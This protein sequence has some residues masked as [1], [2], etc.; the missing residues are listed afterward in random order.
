MII[1][2]NKL[3]YLFLIPSL[4][5]G[6][7]GCNDS[8]STS[9]DEP[10]ISDTPVDL[11]SKH[12]D[13]PVAYIAPQCYTKTED[14][15]SRIYNSCYTCHKAGIEPNFI[16]DS[17]LQLEYSFPA[18]A[19]QNPWSNL[20]EDRSLRIATISDQDILSYV[21][22][23]NYHDDAGNILLAQRLATVPEGWDFDEDGVWDGYVPDCYY[24]FDDEGFDRNLSNQYTGWRSF[25]YYPF[26][27]NWPTNGIADDVLIRLPEDFRNNSQGAFDLEVYKLN[28]AIVESLILRKNVPIA[29]T[30]EN[31]YGVDLDKDGILGTATRVTYDWAPLEGRN[32]SYVGQAKSALENDQVHLA[33]GL[34]PEGTEFA[35]SLRYLDVNA[36]GTVRP[37]SRMKELRYMVKTGWRSYAYLQDAALEDVKERDDFPDRID[38]YDS[39]VEDGIPNNDTGWRLQAF[40]EDRKGELRPQSYEET[41]SCMGCHG[42]IGET[43]DSTFAFARKLGKGSYREGWYHWSQKGSEGLNEPKA[44]ILNAGVHYDYSYYLMYNKSG[45]EF[46]ANPEVE[47]KYFNTDGSIKLDM[48]ELL[49]ADITQLTH[50]SATRALALNKA[51]RIIVTDQDFTKGRDVVLQP[52]TNV[53]TSVQQDLATG[54]QN[55]TSI[56]AF[57]GCYDQGASCIPDGDEPTLDAFELSVLGVGMAGPDGANYEVDW[58]GVIHKSQYSLASDVTFTFPKRLTLPTKEIVPLQEIPV[59]YDCH[60]IDGPIVD[61]ESQKTISLDYPDTTTTP[62]EAALMSQLTRNVAKDQVARWS[63]DGSTIAF[64]SDRSGIDQIWLMN[65][66]G[67]NIR[68]LTTGATTKSAWPDWSDDSSKIVYWSHDSASGQHAIKTIEVDGSNEA[69]LAVSDEHLDR[70]A[71]SPNGNYVAY[72]GIDGTGNWDLWL[73]NADGTGLT[74]LTDDTAMETNPLWSPDG[75]RIAYKVAPSGQ[76]SLTIQNIMTFENG[77]DNPTVHV[78][79]GPEAIQMY[80][81]SPDGSQI[82]YTA[83]TISG[84]SGEDRVTYVNIVSDVE[85][86]GGEAVANPSVIISRGE[87]LGD[88]GAVFSPDGSKVAFWAWDKNFRYTL[89]LYDQQVATVQQLTTSGF[90]SYPQ[91]S[92]NGNQLV[93]ESE[94][95]GNRDL[96]IMNLN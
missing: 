74:R 25:A 41:L 1:L 34:Y 90:D 48:I 19:L 84:S 65:P 39:N 71:W 27:G 93:F 31:L 33:A 81:W 68:Q 11:K 88:R 15:S 73:V 63:P 54:V 3:V 43:T 23:D 69:T 29:A 13:N 66:D 26:L 59:C 87:T 7:S 12:L 21:R 8:T 24:N 45:S 46:R 49:H 86:V 76:Y 56:A 80:D 9:D 51:Y 6:L 40:I 28:L 50:P 38:V 36:D 75:S 53:Y 62:S 72:A 47:A 92:P 82:S 94:R 55:A 70:P 2:N 17:D 64:V 89:W 22:T 58:Q 79:N 61:G 42:N 78:W 5:L 18:P 37:S 67:T 20:F 32:M 83:E 57:S 95:S 10:F 77:F 4:L 60:R 85:L 35:Q 91:W 16:N 52:A 44:E 30:N 96:W 14:T